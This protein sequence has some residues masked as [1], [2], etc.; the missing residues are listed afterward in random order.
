MKGSL[1]ILTILLMVLG[2]EKTVTY[3]I[4]E[5]KENDD[6]F[7]KISKQCE[8]GELPLDS[9]NCNNLEKAAMLRAWN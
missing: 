1:S 9:A 4:D 8:M 2:C 5:L 7:N 3:S 6:V